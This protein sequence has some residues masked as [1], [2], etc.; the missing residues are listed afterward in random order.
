MSSDSRY[1]R[2]ASFLLDESKTDPPPEPKS[3]VSSSVGVKRKIDATDPKDSSCKTTA[4]CLVSGSV[5][6]HNAW[7]WKVEQ[8]D[9]T[10]L[11]IPRLHDVMR[12][13]NQSSGSRFDLRLPRGKLASAVLQHCIA[14]V[15]GVAT[16]GARFKVGI[17]TDPGHRWFNPSYGYGTEGKY[18]CMLVI[19]IVK[20]MEAAT[21]IE[22]ALIREFRTHPLC[23]NEAAGGEGAM[24]DA[25]PGFV[26]VVRSDFGFGRGHVHREA[27]AS[28]K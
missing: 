27:E 7:R 15:A 5:A 24:L 1:E 21:Y 6:S 8:H 20:T 25:S 19:A 10:L 26:Y 12:N 3:E 4:G 9:R 16:Q 11:S 14:I 22:A 17:S 2:L 18:E 13:L 23:D 28:T